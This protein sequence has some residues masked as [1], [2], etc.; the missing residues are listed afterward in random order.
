MA[1][2][3]MLH[4]TIS[5][6]SDTLVKNNGGRV[7]PKAEIHTSTPDNYQLSVPLRR[8]NCHTFQCRH[9]FQVS[10]V[11]TSAAHRISGIVAFKVNREGV[12]RSNLQ[13]RCGTVFHVFEKSSKICNALPRNF[14]VK[15]FLRSM[16]V[17]RRSF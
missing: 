10:L 1:F 5:N 12:T 16:P 9:F 17:A 3:V 15:S 11:P 8:L 6:D 7:S 13:H 4:R 14:C 2:K